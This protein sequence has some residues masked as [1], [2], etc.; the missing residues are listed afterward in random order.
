M[1][2]TQP[3]ARLFGDHF[4]RQLNSEERAVVDRV[5]GLT[6]EVLGPSAA[7]V[8][9]TDTFAWDTFRL[10]AREGIVGTAFPREYGGSDARQ[11]LRIRI[12]EELGRVCST[13]ASIITG[14]DLSSRAIVAGA[15]AEMKD[16]LLPRLCTGEL[17]AAFALTEPEAGSDV[18][19][20]QTRIRR[21]GGRYVVNGRKKFITRGTTSDW[22]VTVGRA[23]EDPSMFIAV[24]V[25]RDAAGF[26][27]SPEVGKL[28][29]YG[30]PISSLEFRDVEVPHGHLL[31]AEGEGFDLAQ[32]ALLRARIGHAAMA[33]GRA[34]GAVEIAATYMSDRRLFGKA[35]GEHQGPQWML[36]DMVTKIEATRA[37]VALAAEKYDAKDA[38]VAIFAS[39]AK[40]QATDLCMAVVTDALQL[41]GG[42]GYLQDFPLQRFFRD[43]K[44]NQIGEGSSEVHKTV[45]GRD[46]MRRARDADRNPCLRPGSLVEY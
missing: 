7:E 32:D 46:V 27:I 5:R 23:E 38:D 41:T 9:Q 34:I 3:P 1:K 44:L 30:V 20:L 29:W 24:L 18:R 39:M 43:A 17:Q 19:G 22:F 15:A 16:R 40:L 21:Q 10:L 45:I 11:V 26:T 37:L 6:A 33:L 12:I 42:R 14:T 13:S 25:P 2:P 4:L 36:A 35:L 28:G 31:G 8:A